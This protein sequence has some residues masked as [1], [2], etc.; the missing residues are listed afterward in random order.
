YLQNSMMSRDHLDAKVKLISANY[1]ASTN[2]ADITF[3]VQ[4]G[5]LIHVKLQGAHVWSWTKKK[6]LPVY[7]EVGIDPEIIQEGRTNLTSHLKSKG[8]V[9]AKV[10]VTR[11]KQPD[12]ET[13][14]YEVLKGPRHKVKGVDV[15]GNQ[16]LEEGDLLKHAPVKKARILTHGSYSEK[17][18]HTSV[19]NL[20]RVYQAN[21]FSD[22]KVTPEVHNEAGNIRVT[23]RV[24]EGE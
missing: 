9:D 12:G 21:G 20:Q 13:I 18:V 7:Q 1:N 3:N 5:P 8:Y 4:A 22:V 15:A 19:K 16:T 10:N 24:V 6:L 2:H 23:F 17:L 14:V 11:Q